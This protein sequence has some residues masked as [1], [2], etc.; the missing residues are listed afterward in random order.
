MISNKKKLKLEK[1]KTFPIHYRMFGVFLF[2]LSIVWLPIVLL[3]LTFSN[4]PKIK[5]I[6]LNNRYREVFNAQKE[7]LRGDFR[8]W[9]FNN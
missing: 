8:N 6:S 4:N 9:R 7:I 5:D 3:I 2:M 1:E